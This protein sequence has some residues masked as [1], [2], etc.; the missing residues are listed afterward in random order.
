[1]SAPT[2]AVSDF[3]FQHFSEVL[4]SAVQ[5]VFSKM[6][7]IELTVP[8]GKPAPAVMDVTGIVGLAGKLCGVLTVRCTAQTGAIIASQML[9]IPVAEAGEQAGDAIGEI[10][11]MVAG[12]FKAKLLLALEDQ[13]LLSVPT[14]I[15]GRDYQMHSLAAGNR[16]EL[17]FS[18]D[19]DVFWINLE[20]RN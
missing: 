10:S 17:P 2:Q 9:G 13:C 16:V 11:N 7:G 1:M 20:I 8:E 12:N 4:H 6:V 5:E 18:H 15:T 19:G 14:V 3:S